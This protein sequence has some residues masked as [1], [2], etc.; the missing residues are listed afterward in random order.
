MN[1]QFGLADL[2]GSSFTN[3]KMIGSVFAE[4]NMT[5]ITIKGGNWSYTNLR[6]QH[7]K[8]SDFSEIDFTNADLTG[9]NLEGTT[10]YNTRLI[11]TNLQNAKIKGS[12]LRGAIIKGV[13]LSLLELKDVQID[14]PQCIMLALSLGAKVE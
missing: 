5:G 12:D 11:H 1:C 10:F 14:V 4:T 6:N 2:F 8:G 3:C 9:C 13:N 7:F